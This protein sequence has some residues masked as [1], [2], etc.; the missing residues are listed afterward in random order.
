MYMEPEI[1]A[2]KNCVCR[3]DEKPV[4]GVERYLMEL[5]SNCVKTENL[6]QVSFKM[7]SIGIS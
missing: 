3:V 2:G 4:C 5:E 1:G 7:L 6:L